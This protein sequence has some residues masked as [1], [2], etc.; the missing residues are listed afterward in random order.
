MKSLPCDIIVSGLLQ[1]SPL[2]THITIIHFC[3]DTV[4]KGTGSGAR[5][6]KFKSCS[7]SSKLCGLGLRS[8][9][10]SHLSHL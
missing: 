10:V 8:L 1:S 3:H 2:I 9:S 5:T 4:V 6:P 7:S